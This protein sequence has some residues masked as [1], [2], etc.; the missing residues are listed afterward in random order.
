MSAGGAKRLSQGCDRARARRPPQ[1][2]RSFWL[3]SA[4]PLGYFFDTLEGVEAG[5][6][7]GAEDWGNSQL[8]VLAPPCPRRLGSPGNVSV[9][10]SAG[11]GSAGRTV[12]AVFPGGG[13]RHLGVREGRRPAGGGDQRAA[14]DFLLR[15]VRLACHRA[16]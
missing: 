13:G 3:G 11:A 16:R 12:P 1:M 5:R 14:L 4:C 2:A 10:N 7:D 8:A 15:A 6:S 9:S